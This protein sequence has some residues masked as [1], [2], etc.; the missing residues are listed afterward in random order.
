ME[1]PEARQDVG[2]Q[3][4]TNRQ[5]V[6]L[7]LA[8]ARPQGVNFVGDPQQFLHMTA[9]VMS[10]D[11]SLGKFPRRVKTVLELVEE[12]E[13]EIMLMVL[14]TV[15]GS[16]GSVG[17]P[18]RRFDPAAEQYQAR[19]LVRLAHFAELLAPNVLGI[20]QDHGHE[21]FEFVLR[22]V[23]GGLALLSARLSILLLLYLIEELLGITP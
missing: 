20:G 7:G 19:L 18:A 10:D 15:E 23:R 9:G 22:R 3:F 5:L 17:Q 1:G 14:R 13:V 11:I 2:L 6:I 8:Q 4:Q 12:R 21:V 16:D